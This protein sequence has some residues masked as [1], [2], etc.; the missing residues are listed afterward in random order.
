MATINHILQHILFSPLA[1]ESN[2]GLLLRFV[3]VT[4][5]HAITHTDTHTVGTFCTS[6]QPVAEVAAATHN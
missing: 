2:S 4:R 3:E 1:H 5:S 6:G